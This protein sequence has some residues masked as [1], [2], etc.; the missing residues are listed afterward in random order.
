MSKR[1]FR[2]PK[3]ISTTFYTERPNTV[4]QP[5]K[6]P[7]RDKQSVGTYPS[8]GPDQKG[9]GPQ[10][11]AAIEDQIKQGTAENYDQA[12]RAVAN[13]QAARG[14]ETFTCPQVWMN[15]FRHSR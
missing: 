9:F 11:A 12:A 15:R 1:R 5:A 14:V 13:Q 4:C 2:R 3:Q 10:E 8:G 6:R 7:E